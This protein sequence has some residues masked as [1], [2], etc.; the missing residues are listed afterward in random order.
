[1][2]GLAADKGHVWVPGLTASM[3]VPA[4][5]IEGHADFCDLS[6]CLGPCWGT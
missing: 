5:A 6:C 1:M 4:V 3:S 2:S